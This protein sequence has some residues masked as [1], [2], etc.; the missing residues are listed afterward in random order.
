MLYFV[1]GRFADAERELRDKLNGA[2]RTWLDA[3]AIVELARGR[4][5]L[6]IYP[7][8]AVRDVATGAPCAWSTQWRR[9][10]PRERARLV[11]RACILPRQGS[12][13]VRWSTRSMFGRRG[14]MPTLCFEHTRF[15]APLTAT[16]ALDPRCRKRP[17]QR[18]RSG[19]RL[20]AGRSLDGG[21]LLHAWRNRQR[22]VVFLQGLAHSAHLSQYGI[23][24]SDCP[25]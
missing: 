7:A 23:G 19:E 11:Q 25:W 3:A 1:E 2:R 13:T 9:Y 6:S 22:D 14:R 8:D 4:S 17:R 5:S 18:R 10:V 16:T 21:M 20:V 15:A 12:E 24:L